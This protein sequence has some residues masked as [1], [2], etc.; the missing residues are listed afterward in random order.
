[1]NDEGFA[2]LL[3]AVVWFGGAWYVH[4]LSQDD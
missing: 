1:M 4:K 2:L 3:L